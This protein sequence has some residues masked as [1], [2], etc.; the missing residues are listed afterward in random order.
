MIKLGF[1]LPAGIVIFIFMM[2][3]FVNEKFS[4]ETFKRLFVEASTDITS[5]GVS[6]MVS[7]IIA[8]ANKIAL[9]EELE[10]T[11]EQM[12]IML[13]QYWDL[14]GLGLFMLF[15]YI[16]ALAL[17]VFISKLCISKYTE[18]E[19]NIYIIVGS[20]IGY[21]IAVPAMAYAIVLIKSIGGI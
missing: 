3:L 1:L 11:N 16:I 12:Q 21:M 5:L 10:K 4:F 13:S 14:F 9:I 2:K 20:I 15:L 18:K 8:I 19:K 7:Y 17:V 6:F